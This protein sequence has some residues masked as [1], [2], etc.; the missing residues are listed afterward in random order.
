M[1]LLVLAYILLAGYVAWVD[2]EARHPFRY[3][4]AFSGDVDLP[5]ITSWEAGKK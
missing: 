5:P 4:G 1:K 2:Y 3:L